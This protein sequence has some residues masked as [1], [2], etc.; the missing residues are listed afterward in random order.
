[1]AEGGRDNL[2]RS[3]P[4]RDIR[5]EAALGDLHKGRIQSALELSHRRAPV[6]VRNT[7]T[8]RVRWLLYEALLQDVAVGVYSCGPFSDCLPLDADFYY[9]YF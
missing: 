3:I 6:V 8:C 4:W 7:Y 1:M 5:N 2:H 9:F